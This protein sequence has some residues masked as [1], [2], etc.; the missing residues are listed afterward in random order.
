[1]K[2]PPRGR[3][4]AGFRGNIMA[5]SMRTS[6]LTGTLRALPVGYYLEGEGTKVWMLDIADDVAEPLIDQC[7]TLRGYRYDT[8]RFDVTAVVR[9][10]DG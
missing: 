3:T 10:D 9:A 1:M 6:L 5:Y 4:A 7:V 2:L 8:P